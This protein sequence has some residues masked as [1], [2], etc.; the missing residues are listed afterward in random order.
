MPRRLL[1][2]VVFGAQSCA[3]SWSA[4][5]DM[6]P[7][8]DLTVTGI[9]DRVRIAPY[10]VSRLIGRHSCDLPGDDI[11]V[12]VDISK[13]DAATVMIGAERAIEQVRRGADGRW[14]NG[15]GTLASELATRLRELRADG[16]KTATV[17]SSGDEAPADLVGTVVLGIKDAGFDV[18]WRGWKDLTVKGTVV[19][20][21]GAEVVLRPSDPPCIGMDM[22]D[23]LFSP[24]LDIGDHLDVISGDIYVGTIEVV[25]FAD[26]LFHCKV[27]GTGW[28]AAQ[29]FEAGQLAVLER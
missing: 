8:V 3:I 13:D 20:S 10:K 15:S 23:R 16:K 24:G 14:M 2:R 26:D 22:F 6:S 18:G 29:T 28:V 7:P 27:I 17:F 1:D 19:R 12:R 9:V 11:T 25:H 21:T 5:P 4:E